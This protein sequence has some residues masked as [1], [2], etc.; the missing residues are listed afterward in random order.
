MVLGENWSYASRVICIFIILKT[1]ISIIFLTLFKRP[2]SPSY[3]KTDETT[4]EDTISF[5]PYCM[6]SHVRNRNL[7][8]L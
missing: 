1:L 4:E 2:H 6:P 5:E 3:T 8:R 7:M